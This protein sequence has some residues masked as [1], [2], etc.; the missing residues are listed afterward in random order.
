M[1]SNLL[2]FIY[3]IIKKTPILYKIYIYKENYFKIYINKK[4]NSKIINNRF[5]IPLIVHQSWDDNYF[6]YTIG[7]HIKNFREL[8]PDVQFKIYNNKDVN[9]FM[10]KFYKN[11]KIYEIFKNSIFWPMKTDIFRYCKVYQHGG[12]WFDIKS[13]VNKQLSK[14]LDP[15]TDILISFELDKKQEK[16]KYINNIQYPNNWICNW[17]FAATKKNKILKNLINN[18]CNH[19]E[20]YKDKNFKYP[21]TA[22]LELTGPRMLTNTII[23]EIKT[24]NFRLK[25]QQEGINFHNQ[26]VYAYGGATL[27]F[28][29]KKHYSFYRNSKIIK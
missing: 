17:G 26:G 4:T 8:N 1:F 25:V 29:K 22:I 19:Y 21:K 27:L 13:G 12:F 14:I 9:N 18:I 24:K 20:F 7:K 15:K 11:H 3:S 2:K 5:K 10:K 16:K 28:S 23:D 6:P